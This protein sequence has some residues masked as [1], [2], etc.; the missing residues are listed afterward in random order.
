[1]GLE[2]YD[3]PAITTRARMLTAEEKTII[4]MLQTFDW[5]VY[6]SG[7]G[8]RHFHEA[9][10]E[11]GA[12]WP[13]VGP[14]VAVVGAQTSRVAAGARLPVYFQPTKS[15][16]ATLAQELPNV[17]GARI[18]LPRTTLAS[19]ELETALRRRGGIVTA[20]SVY[21][22]HIVTT[23]DTTL[24]AMVQSGSIGACV[25]ASP[26][27]VAGFCQRV[28]EPCESLVRHV[29]AVA[30]GP[31]VADVLRS[32]GFVDVHICREPSIG[33]VIEVLHQLF[34]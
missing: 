3:A 6:T 32:N 23:P 33:G 24:L 5:I 17:H 11:A 29:P 7:A 1:M 12:P 19:G 21:E 8:V 9:V 25:F 16:S 2:V 26:S 18:L 15:D 30:I 22:T 34:G 27:A 10:V 31:G 14:R 28:T 20:L 13:P 4:G